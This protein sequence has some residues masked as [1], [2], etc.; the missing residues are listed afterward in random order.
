RVRAHA[1]SH[2]GCSSPRPEEAKVASDGGPRSAAPGSLQG[3]GGGR[4][5]VSRTE[6]S[7]EGERT[8]R[9]GSLAPVVA[10]VVAVTRWAQYGPQLRWSRASLWRRTDLDPAPP[11]SGNFGGTTFRPGRAGL[12]ESEETC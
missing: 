7:P 1:H 12:R 8:K 2:G 10:P 9:L 5:A 6:V 4:V 11:K 3:S